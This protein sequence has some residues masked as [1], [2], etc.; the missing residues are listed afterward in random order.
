MELA[1]RLKLT[2]LLRECNLNKFLVTL[3]P[4]PF[5]SR[6]GEEEEKNF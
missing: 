2:A 5:I 3:R 6:K 4:R 1:E